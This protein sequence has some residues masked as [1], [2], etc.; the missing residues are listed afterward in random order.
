MDT[1]PRLLRGYC[2]QSCDLCIPAGNVILDPMSDTTS[3]SAD[4][5][6]A[7]RQKLIAIAGVTFAVIVWGASFVATKVALREVSA[8][9]VVWLRF[10]MGIPILAAAVAARKQFEP[11]ARNEIGYFALL[12]FLGIAFHQ[13]LQSTGLQTA[14]ATT[15]AWI[16][17]TIPVIQA[18]LGWAVLK[19]KLGRFIIAGV[20]LAAVG[21]L[22]VVTKGDLLSLLQGRSGT[23]GDLLVLF[24]APNW[25]VFSILSRRGLQRHRAALMLLYVM[26]IGW[27]FIS[28][29]F[30]AGPGLA[31]IARLTIR[32][33]LAV[34]FLGVFCTGLAYIFYYDTL[35]VIPASQVGV[36]IYIEPLVTVILAAIILPEPLNLPTLL[37]GGIIL[38]G[39][40]L[41]NKTA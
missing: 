27:L 16:V 35:Q 38:T 36:F 18:V 26:G 32:G 15:S 12:G 14:Q 2:T 33:W 3:I 13:W 11:V 4:S 7:E 31:D 10:G 24:S 9:T 30:F 37:G 8:V 22:L 6:A 1:A 5:R 28:A 39:V 34:S 20:T 41:V 23:I 19:E 21:V 17:A 29:L 40:W 25:A